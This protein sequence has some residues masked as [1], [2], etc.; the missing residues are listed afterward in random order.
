M[1]LKTVGASKSSIDR[2]TFI[3]I[4]RRKLE[5]PLT[6]WLIFWQS[7]GE[8][9]IGKF[10]SMVIYVLYSHQHIARG[11]LAWFALVGTHNPYTVLAAYLSIKNRNSGKLVTVAEEEKK[12]RMNSLKVIFLKWNMGRL[13]MPFWINS[14]EWIHCIIV[15]GLIF[16]SLCN[17]FPLSVQEIG[18]VY[19]GL[20]I[21]YLKLWVVSYHPKP[22]MFAVW[23]LCN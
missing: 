17:W 10:W 3:Q 15:H 4:I 9:S 16:F 14:P 13:K 1:Y 19:R 2:Y 21:N 18:T 7:E 11:I 22:W 20:Y 23:R 6:N 12:C 5:E 8:V